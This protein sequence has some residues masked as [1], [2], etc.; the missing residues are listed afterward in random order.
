[1]LRVL[2]SRAETLAIVSFVV[3]N[4]LAMG[5]GLTVAQII[6]PLRNA[7][8]VALALLANFRS[9]PLR[10]PESYGSTIRSVSG[11]C[12]SVARPARRFSRNSPNLQR[13]TL[14]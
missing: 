14:R 9:P 1:M 10:W 12:C 6:E 2:L 4:M 3:S 7:R 5:A 8:L 11:C 13:A